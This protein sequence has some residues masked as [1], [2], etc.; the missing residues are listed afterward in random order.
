MYYCIPKKFFQPPLTSHDFQISSSPIIIS[1]Q[2]NNWRAPWKGGVCTYFSAIF[3]VAW[4]PLKFG[5]PTLFVLKN[6]PVFFSRR[7]KNLDKIAQKSPPPPPHFSVCIQ[8]KFLRAKTLCV[9]VLCY[10]GGRDLSR[11]CLKPCFST[12]EK[13]NTGILSN[14]KNHNEIG[15][16]TSL[17]RSPS[18]SPSTSLHFNTREIYIFTI[19]N[20]PYHIL[21]LPNYRPFFQNRCQ[22]SDCGI[23]LGRNCFICAPEK[24]IGQ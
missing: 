4:N 24:Y 10:G 18:I 12:C 20:F 5:M 14:L 2:G 15:T 3:Q 7:Q 1:L 19:Y 8:T 22:F 17:R 9:C 13:K 11:T 16:Y 23:F 6:V 21:L